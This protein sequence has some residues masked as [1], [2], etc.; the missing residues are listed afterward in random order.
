MGAQLARNRH[1]NLAVRWHWKGMQG[2]E[3]MGPDTPDN[4]ARATALAAL[5]DAEMRAGVFTPS[6]YLFLFP[7]GNKAHLMEAAPGNHH[8]PTVGQYADRYLSWLAAEGRRKTT[9]ANVRTW[10]QKVLE[11]EVCT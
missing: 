1:G 10:L 5:V 11:L 8:P 2:W 9:R 7:K 6:R 3:G 4:R